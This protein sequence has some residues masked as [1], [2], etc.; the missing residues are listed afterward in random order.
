MSGDVA[1]RWNNPTDRTDGVETDGSDLEVRVGLRPVGAP[2]FTPVRTVPGTEEPLVT[3]SN[4]AGGTYEFELVLY[5]LLKDK[6]RAP[7]VVEFDVPVGDLN[8]ITNVTV[9]IT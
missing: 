4:Q 8:P 3:L 1:L 7:I 9:E 2:S 6:P 5:D